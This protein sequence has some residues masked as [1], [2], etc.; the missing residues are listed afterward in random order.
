MADDTN[1][2]PRRLWNWRELFVDHHL[3]DRLE[4]A[5][6]RLHEPQPAGT[7]IAY[8]RPWEGRYCAYITV[9]KDG[10]TY[11]MYYRGY[12]VDGPQV[13]CYAESD[14]GIEW[15]K[16]DLGLFEVAGTRDNNIVLTPDVAGDATHNFSPMLDRRPGIPESEQYKALG[17]SGKNG[18]TAFASADGL[19]WRKLAEEPVFDKGAFDSQNVCFWSWSE[20][21][22]LCYFRVFTNKVR[23]V[24]RTTSEDFLS[25]SEPVEME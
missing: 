11:R 20:D 2:E 8:D 17:G 4:G 12:P 10:E 9:L 22:Y 15:R 14:D 21:M 7:A 18:L 5:T 13:T 24:S 3:I 23:T 16:P 6:L 25:W 19:S 1:G